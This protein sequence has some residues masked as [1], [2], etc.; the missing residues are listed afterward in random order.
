VISPAVWFDYN[1]VVERTSDG[2]AGIATPDPPRRGPP[3]MVGVCPRFE[4]ANGLVTLHRTD[5]A[6]IEKSDRWPPKRRVSFDVGD[7]VEA[8]AREG[9]RLQLSRG[10]CGQLGLVLSRQ[11]ALVLLMGGA[12]PR[13]HPTVTVLEDP[14]AHEVSLYRTAR[15]LDDPT[16]AFAWLDL[17][18]HDL[19]ATIA[20]LTD[21]AGEHLLLAIAGGDTE[22][23]SALNL[24]LAQMR[25]LRK[26]R[27]THFE[28]VP[29]GFSGPLEWAAYVRGLPRER[30]TDLHIRFEILGQSLTVLEGDYVCAATIRSAG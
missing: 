14:R 25:T 24:R 28:H 2:W 6:P 21:L 19:E 23:Q 1:I 11:D 8:V 30:P 3:G 22:Q 10:G 16:C 12:G 15:L 17:A 26:R 13:P 7:C 27:S 20:G 29:A 9:D 5:T 18:G 4:L